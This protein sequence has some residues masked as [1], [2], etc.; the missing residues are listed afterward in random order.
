MYRVLP[1]KD[2]IGVVSGRIRQW[3]EETIED[4]QW[5][6]NKFLSYRCSWDWLTVLTLATLVIFAVKAR[7]PDILGYY[8]SLARDSRYLNLHGGDTLD[9][10]KCARLLKDPRLRFGVDDGDGDED[11]GHIGLLCA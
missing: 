11:V 2:D 8:S 6:G 9:G 5:N 4:W 3:R 7:I 10:M 1:T